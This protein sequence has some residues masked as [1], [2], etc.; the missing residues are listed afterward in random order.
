MSHLDTT[1]SDTL[2]HYA[3]QFGECSHAGCSLSAEETFRFVKQ[4]KTMRKLA[5]SMEEEV[6]IHRITEQRSAQRSMLD[7][8]A[9]RKLGQLVNRPGRQNRPAGFHG[10]SE[11]KLQASEYLSGVRDEMRVFTRAQ[12]R[13]SLKELEGLVVRLNTGI[14]LTEEL[15]EEMY[16]LKSA[17]CGRANLTLIFGDDDGGDAA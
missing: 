7:Q 17:R 9:G 3:I 14:A 5:R 10:R 12:Q 15:E 4:L 6:A 8:E 13:P 2:A 11:M 1:L 16:L